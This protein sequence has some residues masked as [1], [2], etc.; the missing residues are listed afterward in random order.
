[1]TIALFSPDDVTFV[2][3][4]S[5]RELF[6]QE[7]EQ[8]FRYNGSLT[9]PPCYQSVLWTVFNRRVQMSMGQVS[10]GEATSYFNLRPLPRPPSDFYT[11]APQLEKLQEMLSS[12]EEAPP[13]PLIR[14]YR[15]P[16]PLNQRTVFA[17]FTQGDSR[18]SEEVGN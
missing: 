3:A 17:S 13:E 11:A 6:P 18:G 15:V 9:T 16:Q 2:P 14:N 12:T 10:G 4:F 5:V 1:M 8:F 7:L